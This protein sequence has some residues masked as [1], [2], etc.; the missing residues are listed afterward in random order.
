M[1]FVGTALAVLAAMVVLGGVVFLLAKPLMKSVLGA[2][3]PAVA[4][5]LG[6]AFERTRQSYGK[7]PLGLVPV[8]EKLT[9]LGLID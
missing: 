7:N 3:E 8:M 9:P 4:A 2:L 1:T 6:R 5:G